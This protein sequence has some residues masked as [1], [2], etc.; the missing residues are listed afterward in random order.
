[1]FKM[2]LTT[3]IIGVTIIVPGGNDQ[4]EYIRQ[5]ESQNAEYRE[6]LEGI[7]YE[8]LKSPRVYELND[9][10]TKMKTFMDY[11]MITDTTAPQWEQRLKGVT[12]HKG[13]RMSQGRLQMAVP[14]KYA[15]IGDKID[16]ELDNGKIIK[17]IVADSKGDR[18]FH[19]D[20]SVIEFLVDESLIPNEFRGEYGLDS[21]FPGMPIK[22]MNGG[23]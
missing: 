2:I 21:L 15:E 20:G 10:H 19:E 14:W 3:F 11:E 7:G 8:N 17:G 22:I 18:D 13:L 6:I 23:K 12:V 9:G 4:D 16:V 5:L 1:M